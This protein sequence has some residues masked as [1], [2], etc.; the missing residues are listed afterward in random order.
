MTREQKIHEA[1]SL[2][3]ASKANDDNGYI[4]RADETSEWYRV[5]AE[6]LIELSDLLH[7]SDVDIRRDAYSHWCSSTGELIGSDDKARELNLIA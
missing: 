5:T 4:Y 1:T 6:E 2:I 7:H 3:S